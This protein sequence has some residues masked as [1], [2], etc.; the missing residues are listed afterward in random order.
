MLS[1]GSCERQSISEN[2]GKTLKILCILK[3]K[4]KSSNHQFQLITVYPQCS[5]ANQDELY[6]EQKQTTSF[7][8]CSKIFPT[9]TQQWKIPSMKVHRGSEVNRGQSFDLSFNGV[10]HQQSPQNTKESKCVRAQ[11][12]AKLQ[13][14]Q[15]MVQ[16]GCLVYFLSFVLV[17]I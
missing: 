16:K 17:F 15:N 3:K 6:W 10:F 14:E 8:C 5:Q 7:S 13:K 9:K 12:A 2:S 11:V 4:K 1:Q